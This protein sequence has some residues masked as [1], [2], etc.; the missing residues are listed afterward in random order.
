MI[1]NRPSPSIPKISLTIIFATVAGLYMQTQN[2]PQNC[3]K[4]TP[5]SLSTRASG[6]QV[7]IHLNL[8]TTQDTTSDIKIINYWSA[9]MTTPDC[10]NVM[11][12]T[13]LKIAKRSCFHCNEKRHIYNHIPVLFIFLISCVNDNYTLFLY[14]ISMKNKSI[15]SF[16]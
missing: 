3:T 13:K 6:F 7:T 1:I 15:V 16:S 11:R 5:P 2:W 14:I 12:V 4:K 9:N 8:S 10:F